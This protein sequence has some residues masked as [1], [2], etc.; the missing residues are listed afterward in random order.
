MGRRAAYQVRL[1]DGREIGFGL[2]IRDEVGTY[3][4]QFRDIIGSK[5]VIRSTGQTA[6]PRALATAE[7]MIRE[8]Y[9]PPV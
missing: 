9:G 1:E 4:V 8:H 5:Y 3:S 7:R 6:R 2:V